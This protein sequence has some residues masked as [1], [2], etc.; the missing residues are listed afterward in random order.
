MNQALEINVP[1]RIPHVSRFA[2]VFGEAIFR[3]VVRRS[4]GRKMVRKGAP[5]SR[6][7]EGLNVKFDGCG[8]DAGGVAVD[9]RETGSRARDADTGGVAERDG[10]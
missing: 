8:S 3:K 4:G 9:E 2:R 5:L 6:Y 7:A 10:E 1:H